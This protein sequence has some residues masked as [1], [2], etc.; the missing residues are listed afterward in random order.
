MEEREPVPFPR[1]AP[2]DPPLPG[3]GAAED[4]FDLDA[5]FAR[6]IADIEA[7]HTRIPEEWELAGPAISVSLGDAADVDPQLLAAMCGPDGLGGE[8]LSAAFGQDKAAD[9]LRPGPVLSA[10][11]EQAV[12]DLPSLS[13]DQLIG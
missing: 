6:W 5:D 2:E 1:P 8:A 7:G 9:V 10:L 13:D 3:D 11:T 12:S 4:D